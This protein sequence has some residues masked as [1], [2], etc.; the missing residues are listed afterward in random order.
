MARPIENT[1]AILQDAMAAHRDALTRESLARSSFRFAAPPDRRQELVL[2]LLAGAEQ[3]TGLGVTQS[4]AEKLLRLFAPVALAKFEADVA[5]LESLPASDPEW[6][7]LIESLTVH[8]TYIMR[9]ATQLA[10]FAELLPGMIARAATRS[11]LLRFWS[12]GCASGEEAYS[13]AALALDVL[14]K[15]GK[16]EVTEDGISLLPP[17]RLEVIGA[18][19]SRPALARAQAGVYETGPLSS[20][21]SEAA[22]LLHHFPLLAA[23]D[24]NTPPMRAATPALKRVVRFSQ[25]NIIADALPAEPF[26]AVFCRNIFIYFSERARREA[27]QRLAGAVRPGGLL[28]LGPTDTLSDTAA[29]ETLWAPGA[30][31]YRRRGGDA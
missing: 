6:L 24:K 9:D 11:R 8:E 13:I 27:Q 22:A 30:L 28:L 31:A 4:A 29:F 12:V 14:T 18:D 15:A 5:R 25:F 21:R 7:A 23:T 16:A 26:D 2:R 1:L 10:F 19:I 20:F 3:R 17:W